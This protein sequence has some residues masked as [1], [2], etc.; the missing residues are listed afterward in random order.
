MFAFFLTSLCGSFLLLFVSP[1]TLSPSLSPLHRFLNIFINLLLTLEALLVL[2][3]SIIGTAMAVIF[4]VVITSQTELNIG[5]SLGI[6]ML[7][8]MWIATACI[9][10]AWIIHLGMSCCC[11]GRRNGCCGIPCCGGSYRRYDD[12]DLDAENARVADE[13]TAE[14]RRKAAA[15]ERGQPESADTSAI[16]GA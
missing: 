1:V 9:V 6:R 5:A 14:A 3:A 4:K 7:V 2:V 11:L 12:V 10:L 15:G 13:K 8:F 16:E